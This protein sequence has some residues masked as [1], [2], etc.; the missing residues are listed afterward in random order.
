MAKTALKSNTN[1][2][3][4]FES[5]KKA[6]PV[7]KS[8]GADIETVSA[9]AGILANAGIKASDAGTTL[10]NVF[11][12]LTGQQ[13]QSGKI[14]KGLGIDVEDKVTGNL[15]NVADIIDDLNKSLETK[16]GV[17][18]GAIITR[19]F[20]QIPLAGVNVLLSKGGESLRSFTKE[21]VNS[22]GAVEELARKIRESTAGRIRAMKSAFES[23]QITIFNLN[24]GP[25]NNL[26]L[27]ITKLIRAFDNLIQSDTKR[28]RIIKN[29]AKLF[30]ALV[31]GIGVFM[32]ALAAAK[33]AVIA[34][35]F[36]LAATPIGLILAGIAALTAA[37]FVLVDDWQAVKKSI[38]ETYATIA[39]S[40][41][42]VLLN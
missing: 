33:V 27:G 34:F 5:L 22:E 29:V 3:M 10:K 26:I 39:D 6:G 28:A 37:L 2:E 30:A 20:G 16:T 32:T 38:Q 7:A 31:V 35:S 12:R 8:T 13:G 42:G 36:I 11:S 14:L 17:E 23:L 4:L 21:L 15:R 40:P 1:I 18:R 24:K 41:L 19:L 9:A 25:L